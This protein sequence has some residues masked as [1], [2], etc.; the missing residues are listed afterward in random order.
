MRNDIR[1]YH[2]LGG[3]A[4]VATLWIVGILTL[5][6]TLFACVGVMVHDRL[7]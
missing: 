5:P 1:W 7:H 3:Y 6:V 2:W 4:I